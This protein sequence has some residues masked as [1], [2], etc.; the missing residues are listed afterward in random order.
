MTPTNT[1]PGRPEP[2]YL[3][4]EGLLSYLREFAGFAPSKSSLYQMTMCDQIPF[5]KG[6][7]GRLLFPIAEIR[8]WV[9]AG[10]QMPSGLESTFP[11][12][13]PQ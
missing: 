7:G 6:P 3:S 4:T 12:Q 13:K 8:R 2:K 9:E 11:K 10:G 1:L 5:I